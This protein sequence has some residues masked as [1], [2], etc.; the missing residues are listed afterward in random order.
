MSIEKT[1][2]GYALKYFHL[3]KED[4]EMNGLPIPTDKQHEQIALRLQELL[5]HE[6]VECLQ[7]ATDDV[8]NEVR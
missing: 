2:S 5:M 7:I 3:T 8:M 4:F 1:D 6:W